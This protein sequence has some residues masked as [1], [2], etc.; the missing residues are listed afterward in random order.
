MRKML[1]ACVLVMFIACTAHAGEMQNGIASQTPT[2]GEIQNGLTLQIPDTGTE[3]LVL[4]ET[5]LSLF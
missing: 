1:R 5:L 4:L 3:I 2:T